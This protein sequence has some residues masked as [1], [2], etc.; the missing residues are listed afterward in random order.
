LRANASISAA[1]LPRAGAA[2]IYFLFAR[3]RRRINRGGHSALA[4][5]RI[6]HGAVALIL[7]PAAVA[8]DASL[9]PEA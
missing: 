5:E 3:D 9:A 2:W 7:H 4:V 8:S 1:L 6:E